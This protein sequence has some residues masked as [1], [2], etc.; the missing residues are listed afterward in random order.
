MRKLNKGIDN[1][2]FILHI[3]SFRKTTKQNR[4]NHEGHSNQ[5]SR[6]NLQNSPN[7]R[8][9]INTG[10]EMDS[11]TPDGKA[12]PLGPASPSSQNILDS[13]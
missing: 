4:L 9:R 11:V 2:N 10:E 3:E 13:S 5:D 8:L 7:K 12:L 1:D 6:D